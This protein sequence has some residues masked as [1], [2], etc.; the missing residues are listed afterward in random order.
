MNAIDL[1]ERGYVPDRVT[2]AGMRRLIADRLKDESRRRAEEH[3]SAF[4]NRLRSSP[5]AIDTVA[6]NEQ[7]YEVPAEFFRLHLG[8]MLKYSC[9]LYP[10]G[11]ESLAEAEEVMLRCYAERAG[12]RD[13]QRILDLGCGWGALSL[14][15]AK[16]YPNSEIV[17]LSNSVGQRNFILS[18]ADQVGLK[19]VRVVTGNIVDFD[20]P[21]D[22]IASGFDRVISI[23]MLEHMRNYGLL[24]SKIARWLTPEGR[25]FV[26]MFA[27]N[28]LSYPFEDRDES[29][30]MT[31]YFFRGGLMPSQHLF[32]HFQDDLQI[33]RQWWVGGTH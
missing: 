9:C 12:L 4:V 11:R 27:H 14:W 7:H 22:G 17:G 8:P 21:A 5:I 18:R 28:T 19:N 10:T 6:A 23:E 24:F 32:R 20:F 3:A 2:R 31:R 26:H 30:W 1:C 13:G 15:L 16:R 29:D 25:V 33:V